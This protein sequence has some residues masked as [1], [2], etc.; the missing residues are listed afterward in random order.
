MWLQTQAERGSLVVIEYI[1]GGFQG[2]E[3]QAL[4][5]SEPYQTYSG[6]A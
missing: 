6:S 2:L 3:L 4:R 1:T 5:G